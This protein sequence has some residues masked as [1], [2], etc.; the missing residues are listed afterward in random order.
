MT[1]DKDFKQVFGG[2][3]G[4]IE[5]GERLEGDQTRLLHTPRNEA[6]GAT[7]EFI[8]DEEFQEFEVRERRDFGLRDPRRQ[9]TDS[10]SRRIV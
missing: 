9:G 10:M 8:L 7:R 2:R 6:I 1:P 5:I 4:P 3:E